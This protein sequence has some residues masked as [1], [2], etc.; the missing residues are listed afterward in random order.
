MRGQVQIYQGK[1]IDRNPRIRS[2]GKLFPVGEK[3][4]SCLTEIYPRPLTPPVVQKFLNTRRPNPGARVIFY[5]KANDPRI[6]EYMTHGLSTRPSFSAGALIN[7][8]PK[9]LFQQKLSEKKES[10]YLS[11][12]RTPLGKSYDQT[13]ALPAFMNLNEMT[14]GLRNTRG[15]SAGEIINPPKSFHEV[16]EDTKQGHELYI[17]THNDYNVGEKRDRKYDVTKYEKD[18]RFGIDTPHHNDGRNVARC[19]RWL[20]DINKKGSAHIVLKRLDDFREKFQPQMGKVFDPIADTMKVPP[21]HTF[22]ILIRPDEYGVGDILHYRA[23][24]NFLRGKDRHRGI[25]AAVQQHLKK[26][27]YHNFESLLEAFRHYDKNG[28]GKIDK[29]EL[30]RTCVQFGLDLD[31]D[32]LDALLEYCDVDKDG[33]INFIEFANFLNWKDKMTIGK[34]EERILTQGKKHFDPT[35][36]KG[37]EEQS[38]GYPQGLLKH[39]DLTLKEEGGF[40]KTPKTF[41]KAA[42]QSQYITAS[43]MINAVVGGPSAT[44]YRTYGI[45]T[46]RSDIAPP[47]IRKT[48]EKVNYGDE[49]NA[50]G[51]LCPSVF[52][53]NMVY[54]NDFFKARPKEEIAQ[55][56]HNIGVNIS[57]ENF[58]E[59]WTLASMRHPKG[60]VS[61][62]TVRNVLHEMN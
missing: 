14:F 26:A 11:R 2:A 41:S 37:K 39:E 18:K 8:P 59:M 62:E 61:V 42:N 36:S 13:T 21:D 31:A 20:Q 33:L 52:T 57:Y 4:A 23:S 58:E 46:V 25:L 35:S 12:Q 19:V 50:Y 56:L 27:N 49:P 53:E 22:G 45:P 1:F 29:E 34:L 54:E 60:L 32:L 10:I 9:T 47:R 38:S 5:G 7:L 51:L 28:D 6:E 15:L 40:E 48:S 17:V 24:E 30:K 3:A 55:I 43:S 16:E 44:N